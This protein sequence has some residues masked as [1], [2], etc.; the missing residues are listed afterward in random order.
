MR[1]VN[2]KSF[3][4]LAFLTACGGQWIEGDANTDFATLDVGVGM[5]GDAL[6]LTDIEIAI[7]PA[8]CVSVVAIDAASKTFAC[9]PNVAY[10]VTATYLADA[11]RPKASGTVTLGAAG[12][13]LKLTIIVGVPKH[14]APAALDQPI[15]VALSYPQSVASQGIA[16]IS[17]TVSSLKDELAMA[18]CIASG[19]ATCTRA[20]MFD[21]SWT[22]S[23]GTAPAAKSTKAMAPAAFSWTAPLTYD[24]V[25]ALLSYSVF[26]NNKAMTPGSFGISVAPTTGKLNIT[27]EIN[28]V[29]VLFVSFLKSY[30]STINVEVRVEDKDF[31]GGKETVTV[32]LSLLCQRDKTPFEKAY[33]LTFTSGVAQTVTADMTPEAAQN[34]YAVGLASDLGGQESSAEASLKL[35]QV[36]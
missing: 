14:I 20:G 25:S 8:G 17:M 33:K 27:P 13:S 32:G 6:L 1:L 18:N 11:A 24:A 5:I 2:V 26:G 21:I 35:G 19:S 30:P 28:N 34:C 10:T 12:A 29:P 9:P 4:T 3:V 16:S 36:Q 22:A 7:A 15:V 31:A 23:A